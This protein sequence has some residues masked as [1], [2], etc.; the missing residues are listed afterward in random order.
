MR[1][2]LHFQL[3]ITTVLSETRTEVMLLLTSALCKLCSGCQLNQLH[4]LLREQQGWEL[5]RAESSAGQ[6]H[7]WVPGEVPST[8]CTQLRGQTALAAAGTPQ[9]CTSGTCPKTP[10]QNLPVPEGSLHCWHGLFSNNKWYYHQQ[11][12]QLTFCKQ[13]RSCKELLDAR[14]CFSFWID[15]DI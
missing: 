13:W 3:N 7:P 11:N 8:V 9:D 5:R 15:K 2:M 10:E 12:A 4:S 14:P 6:C 1:T